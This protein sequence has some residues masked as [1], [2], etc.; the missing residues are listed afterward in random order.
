[1]LKVCTKRATFEPHLRNKTNLEITAGFLHTKVDRRKKFP[2]SFHK[3]QDFS[4][5]FFSLSLSLR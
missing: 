1:M 2:R 5:I 4:A 3:R